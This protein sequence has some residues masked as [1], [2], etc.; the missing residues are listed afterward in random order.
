MDAGPI[1]YA[2]MFSLDGWKKVALLY[3][4]WCYTDRTSW[5]DALLSAVDRISLAAAMRACSQGISNGAPH[6]GR[7]K[8]LHMSVCVGQWTRN[9][10]FF[11]VRPFAPRGA[12][13]GVTHLC[14][15]I[16]WDALNKKNKQ[17]Q[18]SLG[19]YIQSLKSLHENKMILISTHCLH[20]QPS[21]TNAQ[22]DPSVSVWT[23]SRQRLQHS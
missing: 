1:P 17:V 16:N 20:G 23:L 3:R 22:S 6:F 7:A 19:Y 10:S 5:C 4:P 18:S 12:S 15:R 9:W 13:S 21:L 14:V 8:C 11:T 2:C